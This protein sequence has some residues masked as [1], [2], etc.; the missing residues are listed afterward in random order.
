MTAGDISLLVNR[1]ILRIEDRAGMP[2]LELTHDRLTGVVRASRDSRRQREA[3][4]EAEAA[5][6]DAREK[7][8]AA[9]LELQKKTR[10][11]RLVRGLL[12]AAIVGLVAAVAGAFFGFR[13]Q[14]RAEAAASAEREAN[15]AAQAALADSHFRRAR[16]LV[17][18]DLATEA[19]PYLANALRLDP[20]QLP[21][22]A[23]TLSLLSRRNWP[24]PIRLMRG[25]AEFEAIGLSPNG[26]LLVTAARD[27]KAQIWDAETGT[28]RERPLLIEES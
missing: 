11:L 5:E 24:L 4:A 22:H 19:L 15:H 16:D 2:W 28:P 9:R 14:R 8:E 26:K 13:E 20:D 7:A 6:R 3:Q 27:G 25:D 1:R 23:Y 12:L 10:T 18:S 21:V 17:E